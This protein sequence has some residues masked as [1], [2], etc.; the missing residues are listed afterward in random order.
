MQFYMPQC[1]VLVDED[2][3]PLDGSDYWQESPV[4][5]LKR[6]L[7]HADFPLV[8]VE[9][10]RQNGRPNQLT[11]FVEIDGG[12]PCAVRAHRIRPAERLIRESATYVPGFRAGSVASR[13]QSRSHNGGN[14][15]GAGRKDLSSG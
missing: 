5:Q 3:F 10:Q 4:G 6:F 14:G 15:Y 8:V 1:L 13:I 7:H 9:N 12:R 2:P 11:R